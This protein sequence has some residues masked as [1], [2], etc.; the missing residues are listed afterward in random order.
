MANV[1]DK[2]INFGVKILLLSKISYKL[3]DPYNYLPGPVANDITNPKA[4]IM[5]M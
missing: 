3:V 5:L 1:Q 2:N 4:A